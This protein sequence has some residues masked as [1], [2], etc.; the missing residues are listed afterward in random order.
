M[1]AHRS[2][3]SGI[4]ALGERYVATAGYDNQVILWD[5]RTGCAVARG[6]HDHLANACRFG[7]GGDVLLS[8]G[9][10]YSARLWRVPDLGLLAVLRGHEDDVEMAAHSPRGDLV[11]TASRDRTIGVF[12][13]DGTLL[14]R[15]AG[16]ESDVISVAWTST[17]ELVS[18]G[19]DGTVRRWYARSGSALE[20]ID[21]DGAET[22]TIAVAAADRIF[23][24]N[25]DGQILETGGTS[26]TRR[27]HTRRASS[28]SST[29][30]PAGCCSAPATTA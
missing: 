14:R 4:D 22:D 28:G 21:L 17:H 20:V 12:D 18:T 8:S 27:P 15:L 7:P 5:A 24:G 13:A 11:A 23:A 19:D 29:T 2:P 26:V 9:S 3:I 10:D 6:S 30:R 1:I 16:H 25:D